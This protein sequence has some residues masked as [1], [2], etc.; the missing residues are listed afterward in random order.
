M[1]IDPQSNQFQPIQ[2]HS[3]VASDQAGGAGA[4]AAF[5]Q[6]LGGAAYVA[7]N[8]VSGVAKSYGL[9]LGPLAGSLNNSP[10]GGLGGDLSYIDLLNQQNQLQ[11][12]AV[13]FN[14][15]TNISK[16]EHETR[17]SA[18]RNFKE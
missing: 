3:D 14:S 9:G 12:E 18:V 8:L 16:E 1:K 10:T 7:G 15:E 4:G 13:V 5:K 11:K 2:Q 6:V 17:M